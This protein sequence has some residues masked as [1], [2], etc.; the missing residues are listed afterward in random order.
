MLNIKERIKKDFLNDPLFLLCSQ[1]VENSNLLFPDFLNEMYTDIHCRYTIK[2]AEIWINRSG[3][4]LKHYV[5][6]L[7]GYINAF[8][9]GNRYKLYYQDVY[10]LFLINML[11]KKFKKELKDVK[12][13][14]NNSAGTESKQHFFEDN[15]LVAKVK[16][17]EKRVNQLEEEKKSKIEKQE[18]IVLK[19]IY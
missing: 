1:K 7:R 19:L 4:A 18:I 10:K 8:K 6:E 2:E 12:S 17:L 16:K 15:K 9:E 3:S 13:E 5:K 11:I 14:L